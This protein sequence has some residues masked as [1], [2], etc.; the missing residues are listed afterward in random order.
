MELL[1]KNHPRF[2]C[3]YIRLVGEFEMPNCRQYWSDIVIGKEVFKFSHFTRN[4]FKVGDEV[5]IAKFIPTLRHE[6]CRVRVHCIRLAEDYWHYCYYHKNDNAKYFR[7]HKYNPVPDTNFNR[8]TYIIVK[9]KV[10]K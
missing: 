9:T 4:D 7:T 6:K 2:C 8:R 10:L 3:Q 1:S 5:Y